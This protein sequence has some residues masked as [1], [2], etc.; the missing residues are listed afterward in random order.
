[1]EKGSRNRRK[2][3]S[4]D[5]SLHATLQEPEFRCF[6]MLISLS[7]MCMQGGRGLHR[8]C[9]ASAARGDHIL[10]RQCTWVS[11]SQRVVRVTCDS[12]DVCD[13]ITM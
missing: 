2:P 13:F 12:S 9:H 1:M 6:T 10:S 5:I 8:R 7:Q 11:V 3:E 4:E